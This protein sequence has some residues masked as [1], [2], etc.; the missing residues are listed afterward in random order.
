MQT[1]W[2]RAAQSN[3][4]CRCSSCLSAATAVARRTTTATGRRRLKAGEAFTFFYSSIFATAAVADAKVKENR[5]NEWDRV[6]SEARDALKSPGAGSASSALDVGKLESAERASSTTRSS[7][8]GK[9]RRSGSKLSKLRSISQIPSEARGALENNRRVGASVK[10]GLRKMQV[11][12]KGH[13]IQ[14]SSSMPMYR[15]LDSRNSKSDSISQISGE[16]SSALKGQRKNKASIK[17]GSRGMALARKGYYIQ[18]SSSIARR[19]RSS[20]WLSERRSVSPSRAVYRRRFEEKLRRIRVNISCNKSVTIEQSPQIQIAGDITSSCSSREKNLRRISRFTSSS[21]ALRLA[22][23]YDRNSEVEHALGPQAEDGLSQRSN[24]MEED[25]P[26]KCFHL[27]EP[28]SAQPPSAQKNCYKGGAIVAG[29]G[30]IKDSLS[31][32][33]DIMETTLSTEG[34]H[35]DTQPRVITSSPT[36]FTTLPQ[37]ENCREHSLKLFR[38]IELVETLESTQPRVIT[39]SP[40]FFT[41]LPQRENCREHSLKLF[42]PIELVETLESTNHYR[43]NPSRSRSWPPNY[44]EVLT[45]ARFKYPTAPLSLKK[46]KT[47]ECSVAKLVLRLVIQAHPPWKRVLSVPNPGTSQRTSDLGRSQL[48]QQLRELEARLAM[49]PTVP[50]RDKEQINWFKYWDSSPRFPQYTLPDLPPDPSEGK[51]LNEATKAILMS[52]AHGHFNV[53][54]MVDKICYNLLVSNTPPDIHTYNLLIIYLCR[55]RQNEM[56]SMVL[57]S[58]FES[59]IRPNEVT[60]TSTLKYLGVCRNRD[61]LNQF[62]RFMQGMD[63]G[64]SLAKPDTRITEGRLKRL[65]SGKVVQKPLY[66]QHVYG[67]LI[68]SAARVFGVVR[69]VKWYRAMIREGYLPNIQ[70]VTSILRKCALTANWEVGI[71]IW[72]GFSPTGNRDGTLSIEPKQRT[73]FWM[74]CTLSIEPN[75]RTYFWMLR[76]CRNCDRDSEFAAVYKEATSIG[77]EPEGLLYSPLQTKKPAV[78]R[79]AQSFKAGITI[80]RGHRVD[81]LLELE[82][83]RHPLNQLSRRLARHKDDVRQLALEV[84]GHERHMLIDSIQSRLEACKLRLQAMRSFLA[85]I[86]IRIKLGTVDQILHNVQKQICTIISSINTKVIEAK[87]AKLSHALQYSQSEVRHV[88]VQLLNHDL[89]QALHKNEKVICKTAT[90]T[91]MFELTYLKRFPPDG[92]LEKYRTYQK[93]QRK[94]VRAIK[95]GSPE[96]RKPQEQAIA[97]HPRKLQPTFRNEAIKEP[98]ASHPHTRNHL[99]NDTT[100]EQGAFENPHHPNNLAP[101]DIT[102]TKVTP[103]KPR[104]I[105]YVR[106]RHPPVYRPPLANRVFKPLSKYSIYSPESGQLVKCL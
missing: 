94:Y 58:L 27:G 73:Y 57:D 68:D 81:L 93:F 54:S 64:L 70:I 39:S 55:F 90:K 19:R 4:S 106:T 49:L 45:E 78:L 9:S 43:A 76:L 82:R 100:S 56:V 99:N 86:A 7:T 69:A 92:F 8:V 14:R 71:E 24:V 6:I 40:T 15:R 104:F 72:D 17:T 48:D 50:K 74:L 103:D 102:C 52:N 3:C 41:T 101:A 85:S 21:S 84:I 98:D 35:V 38:P 62:I 87:I 89:T 10:L 63:G 29:K 44:A 51:E 77:F 59:H 95:N 18:R 83:P 2:S 20:S 75:E 60:I 46:L 26:R 105:I 47:L 11:A 66:N 53:K 33:P 88:A 67:A 25:L 16:A 28:H 79:S 12:E 34:Y 22:D 97:E 61:G 31:N 5:R 42:R 91:S 65:S 30:T 37:R 1:L 96:R 23:P 32:K 13:H 36:F 80:P